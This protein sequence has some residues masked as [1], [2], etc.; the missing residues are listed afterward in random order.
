MVLYSYDQA[1]DLAIQRY[2]SIE[3]RLA[4]KEEKS[5]KLKSQ[6]IVRETVRTEELV[7]ALSQLGLELRSD[8]RLCEE[9]IAGKSDQTV[10][11]IATV[12]AEMDWYFSHTDY[13]ECREEIIE[14]EME[15]KGAFSPYSVSDYAKDRALDRW[16]NRNVG[17]DLTGVP[18]SLHAEI[19]QCWG[20]RR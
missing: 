15:Y 13:E 2:G 8:S 4:Q 20:R 14:E 1:K 16:A 12:M 6:R 9:Y 7:G 11:E 10:E 5:S 3:R 19:R 17:V 18:P